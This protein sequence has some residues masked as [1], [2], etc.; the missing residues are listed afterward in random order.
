MYPKSII[1]DLYLGDDKYGSDYS[2]E[3]PFKSLKEINKIMSSDF[4]E[5]KEE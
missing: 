5:L 4:I 2:N 1:I 3:R